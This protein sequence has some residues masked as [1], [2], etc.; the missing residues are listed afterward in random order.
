MASKDL[1]DLRPVYLIHGMEELLLERAVRRLKSRLA[2]VADLDFNFDV[3]DGATTPADEVLAA[4]NTLPFASERRLVIVEDVDRM[5]ASEQEKLAAYV[6]DPAEHTCLVMVA[7][8]PSRASRLFKA[9]ESAKSVFEYAA[10]KKPQYPREVAEMFRDRGR[11]VSLD[12]A[13]ILVRAVG[14]D[15]RRL[16]SEVDKVIT[17]KPGQTELTTEDVETVMAFTAPASVFEFLDA[18]GER[19][20]RGA[21][22]LLA[23]LLGEGERLERVHALAVKHVRDLTKVRALMDRGV[24]PGAVGAEVGMPEWQARKLTRQAQ[25]FRC[26]E[27]TG[28][29]RGA[30]DAE[31][32]MKTSRG[33]PRLVF[34]SW[35]VSVCGRV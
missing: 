31:A 7:A 20:L 30:A 13:E 22:M 12:A 25:R 14:F 2:E 3:F 35:L 21:L 17:F 4:A 29:L 32:R 10:P 33:E 1:T 8:K 6:A 18:M 23:R 28:A 15:L 19:N 5:P 34:E 27:L 16:A 9:A 11:K 26:E 24:A